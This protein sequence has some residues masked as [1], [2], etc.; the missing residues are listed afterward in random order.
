MSEAASGTHRGSPPLVVLL[1]CLVV[2][3]GGWVGWLEVRHRS[4]ERR[5]TSSAQFEV[6]TQ[7]GDLDSQAG[8]WAGGR[9]QITFPTS[10]V[11]MPSVAVEL[12]LGKELTEEEFLHPPGFFTPPEAYQRYRGERAYFLAE[13]P[14]AYRITATRD[15]FQWEAIQGRLVTFPADPKQAGWRFRWT[16][17]GIRS[18]LGG[19]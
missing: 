4:L 2:A 7:A 9:G 3:L 10:Y 16:A 14:R 11:S 8:P 12:D 1:T 15:G 17:T 5:M 18:T 19:G 6:L 13:V